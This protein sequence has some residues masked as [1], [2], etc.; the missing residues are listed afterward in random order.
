[1]SAT[2]ERKVIPV[3]GRKSPRGMRS[4]RRAERPRTRRPAAMLS[5]TSAGGVVLRRLNGRVHIALLR[6]QH[7]RGEAWV[8]PKGHVEMHRGETPEDAAVREVQEELGIA[9]VALKRKLGSTQ[10]H[11]HTERGRVTK[12]VHYYLIAGLSEALRAEAAEGL[13]EARWVPVREA[14]RRITYEADRR[15]IMRAV[16][17]RRA[18]PQRPPHHGGRPRTRTHRA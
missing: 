12:T 18:I 9:S 15:I 17:P 3:D 6:T 8:L 10:Y 1:M 11:F 5:E 16:S 13:L 7:A 14:L 2:E 4:P